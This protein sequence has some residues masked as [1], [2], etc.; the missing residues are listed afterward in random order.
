MDRPL[1]SAGMRVALV[2]EDDV[3]CLLLQRVA[4]IQPGDSVDGRYIMRLLGSRAFEAHF[5]PETTG[6]S[7]PHISAEQICNFVIPVPPLDE[8]RRICEYV[9]DE[10]ARLDALCREAVVAIDLLGERRSALISA[11]VTGQID[12]RNAAP[13]RAPQE[14]LIA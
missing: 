4:K 7:V 8:Q 13:Q 6:V 2:K 1:I 11:A 3:P 9:E 5:A 14:E 10:I 12:V